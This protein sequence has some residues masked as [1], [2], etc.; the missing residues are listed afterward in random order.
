MKKSS[1]AVMVLGTIGGVLAAL[2]W[3]WDAQDEQR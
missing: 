2:M 1:F 3:S